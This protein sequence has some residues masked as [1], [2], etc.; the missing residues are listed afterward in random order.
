[1]LVA[2]AV[3]V[4][5]CAN[6]FPSTGRSPVLYLGGAGD[7]GVVAAEQATSNQR[8]DDIR[9]PRPHLHHY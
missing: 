4:V 8:H 1:M 7:G 2:K 9:W 3:V 6:S 5:R